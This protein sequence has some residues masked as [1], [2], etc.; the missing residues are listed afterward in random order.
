MEIYK[1][2][3]KKLNV[4]YFQIRNYQLINNHQRVLNKNTSSFTFT[5]DCMEVKI[6]IRDVV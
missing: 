6:Q 1:C 3:H 5:L 4:Y 2:S